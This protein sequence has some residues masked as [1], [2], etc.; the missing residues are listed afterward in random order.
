MT[1]I[2]DSQGNTIRVGMRTLENDGTVTEI[3]DPDGDV[4]DYGRS[5]G[6]LPRVFVKYDDG[7]DDN[8]PCRW[9]ATGPW[10]DHRDD[11]TCDDVTV[12]LSCRKCGSPLVN[13]RCSDETCPY[14]D[15]PQSARWDGHGYRIDTREPDGQDIDVNG[16][17]N[18]Y[19]V[20][21]DAVLRDDED[22]R[23]A[24]HGIPNSLNLPPDYRIDRPSRSG[25]HLT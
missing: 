15:A 16:D 4:D 25:W 23:C 5:V 6:I 11:Y 1:E 24:V 12:A 21:C 9:N 19:C 22:D 10:D 14:S 8:Y 7:T 20:V 2:L 13:G 17:E 18:R 3:S